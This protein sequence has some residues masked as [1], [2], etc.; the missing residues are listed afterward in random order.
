MGG[1]IFCRWGGWGWRGAA[2]FRHWWGGGRGDL[3]PLVVRGVAGVVVFLSWMGAGTVILRGLRLRRDGAMAACA[4]M[5]GM[6]VV[7][8]LLMACHAARLEVVAGITL[9]AAAGGAFV[10]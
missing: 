7:G 8:G 3:L 5:A 2:F 10:L 6:A 1:W 4:G 9:V